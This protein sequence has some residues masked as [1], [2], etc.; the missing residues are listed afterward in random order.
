MTPAEFATEFRVSRETMERLRTFTS[1]LER[2]NRRINL[3]APAT[4]SDMWRRHIADSAQLLALAP[5]LTRTWADLGTGAGLPGLVIA[6]MA[7]ETHPHL[8]MRLVES[9]NRKAAFLAEAA[10]AASVSV[11]IE[12]ARIEALA[13]AQHDVVSAR[14]LAP[15]PRLLNLAYRFAGP[16]TVFLFPKGARLESELTA[17]SASWHSQAERIVSRTDPAATVLRLRELRPR[18]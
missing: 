6:I 9:D 17:V 13:P 3:V 5:P 16:H 11:A 7:R 14:A 4:I 2:W 10:R 8:T 12:A 18:S 1:L 15:L